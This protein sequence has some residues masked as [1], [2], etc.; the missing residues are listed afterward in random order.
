MELGTGSVRYEFSGPGAPDWY[1]AF[2]PDGSA[3]WAQRLFSAS[4]DVWPTAVH[5]GTDKQ[6]PVPTGTLPA[7]GGQ[8]RLARMAPTGV[9]AFARHDG[10]VVLRKPGVTF[11]ALADLP[12]Q[13]EVQ[14]AFSSD[15]A[16]L[17]ALREGRLHTWA[18]PRA[19]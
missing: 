7:T 5:A 18:I 10:V 1:A 12:G 19:E 16:R 15:G 11:P 2:V 17:F 9:A 13:G 14:L 4:I 3:F 8:T 6:P